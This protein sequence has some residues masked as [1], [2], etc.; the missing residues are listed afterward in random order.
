VKVANRILENSYYDIVN[1][2]YA[3]VCNEEC[4]TTQTMKCQEENIQF[5]Y[6]NEEF[7][8]VIFT[9]TERTVN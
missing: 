8:G 3:Y 2:M 6:V 7:S 1:R 9:I 4:T 5:V